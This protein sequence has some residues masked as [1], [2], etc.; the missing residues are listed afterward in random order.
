MSAALAG[1]L[2]GRDGGRVVPLT[3]CRTCSTPATRPPAP[4]R[5]RAPSRSSPSR[6]TPAASSSP[7]LLP[8]ADLVWASRVVHHLPDQQRAIERLDRRAR[9]R[10]VVGAR[11][12]RP[13]APGVCRGTS[14]SANRVSPSRH[15]P[16]PATRGSSGCG[17]EMPDG[18]AG[19]RSAGTGAL[20]DAGLDRGVLLQLPHRP[21]LLPPAEAVRQFVVDWLTWMGGVGEE[22]LER[23]RSPGDRPGCSTRPTTRTSAAATT[24]SCWAPNTV[25]LGRKAR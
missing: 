18:R 10:R 8:A 12:G 14:V 20:S 23:G 16:P 22:D 15:R 1:A 24:C 25:Y 5:R 4:S 9:A 19:C 3:P 17:T 21:S 2:G 7:R 11:R 13:G 6:W